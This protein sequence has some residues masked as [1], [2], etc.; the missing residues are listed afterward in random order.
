MPS[1]RTLI[2]ACAAVVV[3]AGG[4]TAFLKLHDEEGPRPGVY[5]GERT[6]AMYAPIAT[7][8][9]DPAPLTEQE[10]FG[11]GGGSLT[12]AGVTLA[13][14]SVTVSA[15]CS[16]AVWGSGPVAAVAGC[17]QVLRGVYATGGISGQFQIFNLP[18][19]DAANGLVAALDHN[20]TG[21]L[22]LAPDQPE[23]FDAGRSWAQV[24]ALGHYVTVSWAGPVG[25]ERVDPT[26]AVLALDGLGGVVQG[27]VIAAS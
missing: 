2:V 17:T 18:D 13:R 24:R 22:K 3:L 15:D 1:G 20:G 26:G 23:S 11:P 19:G 5:R 27:R 12:A 10:V 6:S 14:R 7:R 16:T 9:L 8:R 25:D 21:F 4:A